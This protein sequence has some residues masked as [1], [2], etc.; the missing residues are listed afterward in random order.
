V[1]K[2]LKIHEKKKKNVEITSILVGIS[3]ILASFILLWDQPILQD[4]VFLTFAAMLV[5][6]AVVEYLDYRWR[7][8][9]DK[10]LPDLFR[11]IVQAQQTG[12]TLTQAIEEAT[13]RDYG[14]LTVELRKMNAQISWGIPFEEALRSLSRRV[15]TVLIQRT[16]PLIIEAS[17]SGGK[18]EK[19]FDPMGK[20]VQTTL[21]LEKERKTQTRPYIAIIYVAFYV[22]LFTVVLLFNSF[23]VQARE[24]PRAMG[25]ITLTPEEA[26]R[27]FFN[28]TAIQAFF[29]GL[30]AGK[31]GEGNVKAG[32]KHSII[33]LITGYITLK[34]FLGG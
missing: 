5:P 6:I 25:L 10:H 34:V 27:T 33:L 12:M 17:R 8:A 7:K 2:K 26:K 15:N 19:V 30:I 20:F 16:I 29:S 4:V 21:L 24:L 23:F 28:M 3:I 18:I 13:K 11:S 9:V 31:M 22:F 14:A 32:L 1:V